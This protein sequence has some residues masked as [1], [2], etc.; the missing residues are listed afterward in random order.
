MYLL[1]KVLAGL[2]ANDETYLTQLDRLPEVGRN[3]LENYADLVK[4][5]GSDL[6]IDRVFFLGSGI[7]YGLACETMLKMKEMSLTYAEAFHFMEFRHGPK[8]MVN[9]HTLVV[10]MVSDS[11]REQ[12]VAVLREMRGLGARVLAI[13][14]D[15]GSNDLGG[16]D[17]VVP[18]R[19]GLPETARGVLYLPLLQLMAYHRSMAKGLNPDRPQNLDAV[20]YL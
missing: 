8:S 20:V 16:A 17:Y 6:S 19:S 11:T 15:G 5:L 3:L 14:E 10:G 4:Q 13:A 18:L 2:A 12:E 9:D 1:S 7:Y